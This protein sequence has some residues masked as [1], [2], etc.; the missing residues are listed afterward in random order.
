ML[1]ADNVDA[2]N[3]VKHCTCRALARSS[4]CHLK[5]SPRQVKWF[6]AWVLQH[7]QYSNNEL[8]VFSESIYAALKITYKCITKLEQTS[9]QYAISYNIK[10]L[11][12]F[13][14]I[15]IKIK[16]HIQVY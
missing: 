13:I 16:Q 5:W 3:E 6:C 9:S 1:Y 12:Y 7:N 15:N 8:T 14:A 2:V 11:G 4:D 10:I